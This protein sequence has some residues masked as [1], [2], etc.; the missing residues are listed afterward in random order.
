MKRLSSLAGNEEESDVDDENSSDLFNQVKAAVTAKNGRIFRI[1]RN[2]SI[3]ERTLGKDD[4]DDDS[5]SDSG[6]DDDSD[7]D[8]ENRAKELAAKCLLA[9]RWLH[10]NGR[11]TAV[12]LQT[13]KLQ[14]LIALPL[15]GEKRTDS[16][17]N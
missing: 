16:F 4:D 7:D 17:R 15:G 5:D 14:K 3:T 2:G 8:D 12:S 1:G 13:H 9:I 11:L 10:T 6:S